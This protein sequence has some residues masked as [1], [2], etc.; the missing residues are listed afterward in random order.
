MS[1][2]MFVKKNIKVIVEKKNRVERTKALY[3][4]LT[5]HGVHSKEFMTKEDYD[6]HCKL[7]KE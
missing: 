1:H 6:N 7:L 5:P 3:C 4:Y 2:E